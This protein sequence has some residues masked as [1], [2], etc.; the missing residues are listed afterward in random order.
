MS[1]M[2]WLVLLM[3][4]PIGGFFNAGCAGLTR[5]IADSA[6][7]SAIDWYEKEGGKE[8]IQTEAKEIAVKVVDAAAT[9]LEKK[10]DEKL[11][12]VE[13]K[14][15]KGEPWTVA[16]WLTYLAVSFGA[17]LAAYVTARKARQ[18]FVNPTPKT[19]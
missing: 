11:A 10:S 14:R 17:G 2:R 9:V 8:K 6:K 18:T 1:R 3:L 12:A 7:Q 15:A 13:A 16:D 4:V 19:G 5:P